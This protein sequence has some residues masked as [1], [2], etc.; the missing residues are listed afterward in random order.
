[1]LVLWYSLDHGYPSWDGASHIFDA[2]RYA[3]LF[4]HP[5]IWKLAW[6]QQFLTVNYCY[7]PTIH[8]I[9][10]LV[11]VALGPGAWGDQVPLIGSDVLLTLAVFYIALR[12]T[13]NRLAAI[14]SA[15]IVNCIPLVSALSHVPMLDFH[16]LAW[17]AGA[18][19][20]MLWWRD[21]PTWHR[22][23]VLALVAGVACTSK[24]IAPFFLVGPAVILGCEA[25]RDRDRS[26]LAKLSVVALVS[27]LFLAVWVLPQRAEIAS[28]MSRNQGLLASMSRIALFGQNLADYA[29]GLTQ[30]LSPLFAAT[31]LIGLV[32]IVGKRLVTP[33]LTMLLASSAFG[34]LLLS[35]L[36]F[37]LPEYRYAVTLAVTAAVITGT[38]LAVW[39]GS[40]LPRIAALSILAIGLLQYVVLNYC[41]P[42]APALARVPSM[43]G[44]TLAEPELT[45][46]TLKSGQ[47]L[48]EYSHSMIRKN[49]L[50][51]APV[52]A[53]DPFG[54][55]WLVG[56]VGSA[57][58]GAE[59]YV[60][61]MPNTAELNV[62]TLNLAAQRAGKQVRFSSLRVWTPGGDSVRFDP[63]QIGY[64]NWFVLKSGNQG[65]TLRDAESAEQYLRIEEYIRRSGRFA[66]HAAVTLPR[67]ETLVVFRRVL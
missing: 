19:A 4:R 20:A 2:Q 9:N 6:I 41:P 67:Q 33:A 49:G 26:R 3:D 57:S 53:S 56:Q 29:G 8:A 65:L 11:K 47:S 32:V 5:K 58:G 42:L 27:G 28:Y 38:L 52:P 45:F 44:V 30:V 40:A 36:S 18:L 14:S 43:L 35:A 13:D 66:V 17:N 62:H 24:Q 12:A 23:A 55:T 64:F 16:H 61:L 31:S 10:G 59:T 46:A 63:K 21:V 48:T 15:V 25:V 39:F 54:Q 37:Q 51:T 22:T 34:V 50:R 7:P 1:M 60:A